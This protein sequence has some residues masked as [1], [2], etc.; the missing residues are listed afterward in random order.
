M[1]NDSLS[2]FVNSATKRLEF[3]ILFGDKSDRIALDNPKLALEESIPLIEELLKRNGLH[4]KEVRSIYT[5]LGPG[6]NTGIRL[7]LTIPRTLYAFDPTLS[8]YG[9]ATLDLLLQEAPYAA[10]SDRSGNLF[11]ASREEEGVRKVLRNE[12]SSLSLSGPIALEEAD[13]SALEAFASFEKE[14][15]SILSL[16]IEHREK[17]TDY[18]DSEEKLL[19]KYL[20][21][22]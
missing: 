11:F 20:F 5:L 6:S 10:L 1:T 7:G 3:G 4:L 18:S 22:I 13:T 14:T 8:L 21:Q 19:P 17:F 16:M 2:L 12:V 15:Y 9:I